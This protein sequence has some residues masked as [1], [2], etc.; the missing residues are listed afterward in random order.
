MFLVSLLSSIFLN[1]KWCICSIALRKRHFDWSFSKRHHHMGKLG[2]VDDDNIA[3]PPFCIVH[4]LQQVAKYNGKSTV[5]KSKLIA[6]RSLAAGSFCHSF[7]KNL[8]IGL[9]YAVFDNFPFS[10][11][12][13][14]CPEC[15]AY[16]LRYIKIHSVY[17]LIM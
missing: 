6:W 17:C 8:K 13:L 1:N 15:A 10:L 5:S 3:H 12:D 9:R 16:I 11:I 2:S 7:L 4:A 14:F